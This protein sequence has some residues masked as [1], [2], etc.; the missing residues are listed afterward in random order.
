MIK[1][2]NKPTQQNRKRWCGVIVVAV[3]TLLLCGCAAF[4]ANTSDAPKLRFPGHVIARADDTQLDLGKLGHED[5]AAAAELLL[6]MPELK[7]LDLG[8]DGVWTGETPGEAQTSATAGTARDLT[9]EDLRTLQEATPKA[10]LVY[11]FRFCGQDFTTADEEMDLS[12]CTM[13]DNGAEIREILPLMKKCKYVDMDSCGVPSETMAEISADYPGMDIVWRVVYGEELSCRTDEKTLDLSTL[14]H[15]DVAGV[16]EQLALLRELEEIEL[17]SDGAWTGNP[18]ELTQETASV[19]RPAE[20]TRDL[21]WEDLHALQDAAPQAQILYRFRF[22]GRDFTTE[23]EAMDLNHSPMTDNGAA[24]REILPLMKKCKYL[25]MDSC[26]VPSE[27]M[28]EI[29]DDY[30]EMDVV[31]RIWFALG[32]FTVR[33]DIER[34]WCANFYSFM[35]HDYVTELKYCTKL[36]QLDLGHNLELHDWSFLKYMPDLEVLILTASG[37]EDLEMI[38]NCTK[39]EYLE[40]IPMSHVYVDLKPLEK[41]TNLEHL[42]ICGMGE[43]DGWEVLLNMKKLKRLWIGRWTAAFFPDGAIEQVREAL[44]DTEINVTEWSGATGSWRQNPNRSVPE[45][46]RQLSEEFDY[47]HWPKHAPYAYNDPKYNPPW[48]R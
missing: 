28:A 23:D 3:L 8:S 46:Y 12:S 5:V 10:E 6:Q 32:N 45:R 24:V 33:T 4:S 14:S 27:T 39:L 15:K 40:A 20:A 21:T 1:K 25:D 29:R 36:K 9:W 41:L 11:R 43:T 48:K 22:Y 47:D 30:P 16:A 2:K 31:W 17:G 18:P 38:S 35:S 37:W 44:P 7:V 19:E 26:G 42:N 13:T 34:L